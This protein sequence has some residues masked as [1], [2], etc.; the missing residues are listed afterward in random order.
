M[1]YGNTAQMCTYAGAGFFTNSPKMRVTPPWPAR[2]HMQER[3]ST[4]VIN[5]THV[6]DDLSMLRASLTGN[7][8]HTA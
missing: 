4:D 5:G 1:Q 8:E 2:A 6:P 3:S 7:T